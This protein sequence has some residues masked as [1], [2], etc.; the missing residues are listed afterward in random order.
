MK[1][2]LS[3]EL[4][5]ELKTELSNTSYATGHEIN[6]RQDKAPGLARINNEKDKISYNVGMDHYSLGNNKLNKM[7]I[8]FFL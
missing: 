2:V 1:K 4:L 8:I 6:T 7:L 5:S 3:K